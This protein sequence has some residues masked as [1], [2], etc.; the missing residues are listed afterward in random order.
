M[1]CREFRERLS[2]LEDGELTRWRRWKVETHLRYCPDC[3]QTR[4]ELQGIDEGLRALLETDA[5]PAYL[6]ESVMRRLPAMPPAPR[7]AGG[8]RPTL[9]G[10]A[11]ACAQVAALV[12]AYWWGYQHAARGAGGME[13]TGLTSGLGISQ[14]RREAGGPGVLGPTT[15]VFGPVFQS[16]PYRPPAVGQDEPEETPA[17]ANRTDRRRLPMN[18]GPVAVPSGAR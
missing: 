2:A 11:L 10:L 18:N 7:H 9:G 4:D 1:T 12:G 5:G 13:R 14:G 8:L 15:G 3:S 16:R 6:T 17:A